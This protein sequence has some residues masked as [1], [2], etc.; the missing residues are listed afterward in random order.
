MKPELAVEL[1]GVELVGLY[2]WQENEAFEPDP[3]EP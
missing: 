2:E 1:D 3:E